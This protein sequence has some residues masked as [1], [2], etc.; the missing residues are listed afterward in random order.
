MVTTQRDP[1]A[2]PVFFEQ[3]EIKDIHVE[4]IKTKKTRTF[5]ETNDLKVFT[6]GME[7]AKKGDLLLD[8][9]GSDLIDCEV[10]ITFQ[11]KSYKKYFIW[12][13]DNKD[14][15]VM[16]AYQ[17]NLEEVNLKFYQLTKDNSEKVYNLL[18]EI[19]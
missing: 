4:S 10:W 3:K 14:K 12:I 7:T 19:L 13:I 9:E 11:D 15:D 16:I 1:N 8:E 17:S 18:K 2:T 5:T 6:I